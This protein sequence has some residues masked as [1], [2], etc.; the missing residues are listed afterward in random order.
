MK[1]LALIFLLMIAESGIAQNKPEAAKEANSGLIFGKNHAFVLTAPTGWVLDN[2]SG[3]TQGL[4]AVFF[5]AGSS[6][7]DGAA[8]MYVCRRGQ[9]CGY[10]RPDGEIEK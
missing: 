9:S 4:Q 10:D 5:P 3:V 6:W 2:K 8:V 7:K 1:K